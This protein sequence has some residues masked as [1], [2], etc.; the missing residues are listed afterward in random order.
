MEDDDEE[1]GDV[2]V[3][4]FLESEW[5]EVVDG[6]EVEMGEVEEEDGD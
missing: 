3:D 4:F 1:N 2:E 6:E 5:E